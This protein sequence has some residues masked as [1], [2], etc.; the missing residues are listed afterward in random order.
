MDLKNILVSTVIA[1][2]VS[3]GAVMGLVGGN[4]PGFGGTTSDDWNV[5]G[6]LAVTG[7]SAFTGAPT[8]TADA[9]FNGGSGAVVI[10]TTNAATSSASVGCIQTTATSTA[11]PIK[12]TLYATS[13]TVV[14][15]TA[16]TT[17]FGS[18]TMA[19][20]VTWGFGTCP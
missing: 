18:G 16:I 1:L 9:T 3:V 2:I 8:F 7:T 15:G 10:T 13:T 5:G 11:T 4:Q 14:N 20:F 17:S 12:L 6:N 19:G